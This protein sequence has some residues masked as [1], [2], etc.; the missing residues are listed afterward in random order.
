M[1][2][3]RRSKLPLFDI[4][5]NSVDKDTVV[6]KG[7]ATDAAPTLLAGTIALSVTE[8]LHVKKMKLKVYATLSYRWDEKVQNQKGH[9]YTRPFTFSKMVYCFDWDQINLERFLHTHD[10][11]YSQFSRTTSSNSLEN[12]KNGVGFTTGTLTRSNRSSGTN[13]KRMESTTTLNSIGSSSSIPGL[14]SSSTNGDIKSHKSLTNLS[15]LNLSSFTPYSHSS[16]TDPVILQPG[17]Y[18]FPFQCFLDGTIPESIIGHPCCDLVYRLQ[19]TIERGRFSTPIITRKLLHVVRTMSPDNAELSETVAVDN[20]WPGKIDY[21]LSSPTKAVAIGSS[22]QVHMNMQPLTKG[23]KLGSIKVKLVEL[24]TFSTIHRQHSDERALTTKHIPRVTLNKDGIDLWSEDALS[25]EEGVFFRSH[26][27]VLSH[28]RWE[29]TTTIQLPPSLE[30]MTQDLDILNMCKVR[31]KLKFSIALIN[32]DGHVSELR[33]TLPITLFISP[34]VPV[35]VKRIDQYDD[36]FFSSGYEDVTIHTSDETILFQHEDVTANIMHQLYEVQPHHNHVNDVEDVEGVVP[37]PNINTQ[38]LMAPPNYDDRVF[39]RMFYASNA[40][41]EEI[42]PGSTITNLQNEVH[43]EAVSDTE[44]AEDNTLTELNPFSSRPRKHKKP[45]FSIADDDDG[46]SVIT[47]QFDQQSKSSSSK[48]ESISNS[49]LDSRPVISGPSFNSGEKMPI[50]HL[51]INNTLMTP[52][53]LTP[54]QHLSRAT[55]FSN[56]HPFY[57]PVVPGSMNSIDDNMLNEMKK[58]PPYDVAVHSIATV[59]DLT[60]MYPS[61]E[62]DLRGNLHILDSRLQNIRKSRIEG[63]GS[64]NIHSHSAASLPYTKRNSYGHSIIANSHSQNVTPSLSRNI[65]SSSLSSRR[66]GEVHHLPTL[67]MGTISRFDVGSPSR[68]LVTTPGSELNQNIY[69]GKP[70]SSENDEYFTTPE[71]SI[72]MHDVNKVLSSPKAA[73]VSD[74]NT[75]GYAQSPVKN[76]RKKAEKEKEKPG[77]LT[78]ISRKSSGLFMSLKP[79]THK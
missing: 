35:R 56:E 30:S 27:L 28:D 23:L 62:S 1:P 10:P 78:A 13:L 32:P 14:L 51:P 11:L 64:P 68:S 45:V 54:V 38:D 34:F 36:P 75:V 67:Q 63:H 12:I 37:T 43:E 22:I 6:L 19:C 8:P 29:A 50:N 20:T 17:N 44:D 31:H 73:H 41:A 25:D 71:I 53:V 61:S 60:P 49:A 57:T 74:H 77:A 47:N 9:T 3:S 40:G 4:R 21:S 7:P 18:E 5:V 65:S 48:N 76:L 39:D 33:A 70:G 59:S 15:S 16:S 55:S 72:N 42:G 79:S 2:K 66:H 46:D 58:P 24:G 26:N 69:R 52:G